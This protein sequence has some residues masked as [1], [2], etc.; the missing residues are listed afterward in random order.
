MLVR[1]FAL[2]IA[3]AT[4]SFV[5]P[6]AR[7]EQW[8]VTVGNVKGRFYLLIQDDG[9]VTGTSE[10]CCPVGY[11][12]VDGTINNN[13]ISVFRHFSLT[14]K[15]V[16]QAWDGNYS[17]DGKHI[18]G[19]IT[20]AG[21]R[22]PWSADAAPE[23]LPAYAF[24][25]PATVTMRID[26]VKL[27]LR[28]VSGP[29]CPLYLD[30]VAAETAAAWGKA[31]LLVS[32]TPSGL[33][34]TLDPSGKSVLF[35]GAF[36]ASG[37][38]VVGYR[39]RRVYADGNE[40]EVASGSQGIVV[41]PL[42]APTL[43]FK[44]GKPI[45]H[46]T[47]YVSGG[48][49][50]TQANVT[51][52]SQTSKLTLT[53]DDG[54][55]HVKLPMHSGGR[56]WLSTAPLA[57]SES[58]PITVTVGYTDAADISTT[59]VLTAVGGVSPKVMAQLTGPKTIADTGTLNA[60]VSVGVH[61]PNGLAYDQATMGA[62]QA[63]L[64]NTDLNGVEH[65]IGQVQP[66][67]G[68]TTTF[69]VNPS[70]YVRMVLKAKL[71]MASS[72]P[73]LSD[74]R[75]TNSWQAK[76]IKGTALN[77]EIVPQ[78]AEGPVP[79]TFM[80]GL[81]MSLENQV[82]L[83]SIDWQE[84]DDGGGTWATSSKLHGMSYFT[85]M[86]T[87]GRRMVRARL[88]NINS[89]VESHTDPVKLWGYGLLKLDVD[90][91][92]IAAPG[93]PVTLTAYP[94]VNGIPVK[95]AIIEWSASDGKATTTQAGATAKLQMDAPGIY[96]ATARA[97]PNGTADAPN[98]WT[99]TRYNVTFASPTAPNV[100]ASGPMT[101]ETGKA[102]HYAG[103]AIPPWGLLK[104]AQAIVS[105]WVMPDGTVVPGLET[106]WAPS[107]GDQGKP[108]L[109][110]AWVDGYKAQTLRGTK[111]QP[112]LWAYTWP[113]WTMRVMTNT[114]KAPEHVDAKVAHDH[115]EMDNRF[116]G[117]SFKWDYPP[118]IMGYGYPGD[119]SHVAMTLERA[120]S[121]HFG[122]TVSDSRGNSTTLGQ[123][124]DV[125]KPAPWLASVSLLSSNRFN[126]APVTVSAQQNVTGG[127]PLD[128]I[129]GRRWSFDGQDVPA[130]ANRTS[131]R[132]N[133]TD[134]GTHT[135]TLT[136]TS[137]MGEAA[138]GGASMAIVANHPP[139]CNAPTASPV[140]SLMLVNVKCKDVDGYVTG[141]K[142]LLNDVATPNNSYNITVSKSSPRRKY[143][144]SVTA[145]D[146]SGF[147]S[148]PMGVDFTW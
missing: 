5:C 16:G 56:Q 28:Q 1:Q 30:P 39:V 60:T 8:N 29:S 19:I 112:R 22:G 7:Q 70:G 58:R 65:T 91:P 21:G 84:S 138:S 99:H 88:V 110:R 92:R 45:G 80:M 77:A 113:A 47:Y 134:A 109:F 6:A 120:G 20:D 48:K 94:S 25:G 83:K 44:G 116:D 76:V 46:G 55:S 114:D 51:A 63:T 106:D 64:V 13:G 73:L 3:L 145:V 72:N 81:K 40:L 147:A 93:T 18:E 9:N 118:G 128:Y 71:E 53:A 124:L 103:T 36:A 96:S 89:Q 24:D 10:W 133:V 142:W 50:V 105:E 32:A 62:W 54:I 97:R 122:V 66:L 126:K 11:N 15:T 123:T 119:P 38:H 61:G 143:T 140:S 35:T 42:D 17:A 111:L 79:M 26:P 115:A 90:G 108:L 129:T 4:A 78:A 135:F 144:A 131:G 74:S 127:H 121:Y 37:T 104:S 31:C 107:A 137:K 75:V 27:N 141:Y 100:V 68:G 41:K 14:D 57:L 139:A 148:Q 132:F 85:R 102:Y 130:L 12:P 43:E 33:T 52:P 82:A 49:P 95:D 2:V 69:A 34:P 86:K 117:L 136:I 59:R 125:Q 87:S 101:V 67:A 98:A 23:P 146:D